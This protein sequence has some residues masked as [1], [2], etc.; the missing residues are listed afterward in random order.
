MRD[1]RD[2]LR[3]RAHSVDRQIFA[4]IVRFDDLVSR[5]KVEQASKLEH[6]RAQLRLANKLVEFT[7]W[8][9]TVRT[10][11][12]TR[13]AAAEAADDAVRESSARFSDMRE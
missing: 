4:E 13:I 7:I 5:L 11:L 12:E 1:I 8:Q 6:L 2:D 3:D 10:E 9:D